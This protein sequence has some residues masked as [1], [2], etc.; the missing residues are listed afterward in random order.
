[1]YRTAAAC[2]QAAVSRTP[3]QQLRDRIVTALNDIAGHR[4]WM[5][6]SRMH[7]GA[8]VA[9]VLIAIALRL[10]HI[11][12]PMRGDEAW[13]YMRFALQTLP[14]LLSDYSIPNN[15]I[16][17]TL[18]VKLSTTVF[19][20]AEWTIRLPTFVAGVLLVPATYAAARVLADRNAALFA[21]AL[22]AVLPG[23]VLY[24]TNARGYSMICL[25]FVVLIIL[26]NALADVD[27][28]AHWIGFAI[29]LALGAYT[30]PVMLYPAGAVSLWLPM[31]RARRHGIVGLRG[32]VPRMTTALLLAGSLTLLAYAPVLLRSGTELLVGNPYVTPHTWS[33][34]AL[35]V[36]WI[37]GVMREVLALGISRNLLLMMTVLG[38][39]PL[40]VKRAERGRLV[41]L[42]IAFAVWTVIVVAMTHRPPPARAW[43]FLVPFAALYV[44]AGLA[45]AVR[46]LASAAPLPLDRLSA[47]VALT[48]AL[49][50]GTKSVIRRDVLDSPENGTLIDGQAIAQWF[51]TEDAG[52][53]RLV[54]YAFSEPVIDY[55]LHRLQGKRLSDVAASGRAGRVFAIANNVRRE[56]VATVKFARRDVNWDDLTEPV[57]RR[58]FL[59]ATV[60]E[61]S[62]LLR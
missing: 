20:D 9:L 14:G 29:V 33:R 22:V 5:K 19:G 35:D 50:I 30:I 28:I 1:L 39:L 45:Q 15:H 18:L 42:L 2:D 52:D 62:P 37:L 23:L 8:C 25:A 27:S 51:L 57:L 40:F 56:T 6:D 59:R 54:C 55:Y 4:A 21:A 16:L 17:H 47:A 49:A 3:T 34:I 32:L 31:E 24:S 11:N 41:T 13:T 26:A 12:Q 7:Q 36:R 44:G 58:Q 38:T 43:L 53:D 46:W 10:A 48:I 60:Y 61:S